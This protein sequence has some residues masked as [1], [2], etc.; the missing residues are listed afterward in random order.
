M[1]EVRLQEVGFLG[2]ALAPIAPFGSSSL[3][4]AKP[5]SEAEIT[6]HKT[7]PCANR[8]ILGDQPRPLAD[9]ANAYDQA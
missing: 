8:T 7:C 1:L 6:R 5:F 2:P 4:R 9:H 3:E